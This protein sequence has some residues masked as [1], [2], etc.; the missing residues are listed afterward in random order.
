[1]RDI[2]CRCG[3]DLNVGAASH[4]LCYVNDPTPSPQPPATYSQQ[5]CTSSL[6]QIQNEDVSGSLYLPAFYQ[7][8][9]VSF[10]HLPCGQFNVEH[11]SA[12]NIF[13]SAFCYY[14]IAIFSCEYSGSQ[15]RRSLIL[16]PIITYLARYGLDPA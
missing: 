1:M 3:N 9:G 12:T 4:L 15:F 13:I 16:L 10:G 7:N 8:I 2:A 11:S 6:K 5:R 14:T